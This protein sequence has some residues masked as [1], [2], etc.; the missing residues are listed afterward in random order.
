MQIVVVGN[1][2]LN[3]DFSAL[4]DGADEVIR[5]NRANNFGGHGGTRTTVLCIANWGEIGRKIA[6]RQLLVG[7]PCFPLVREF[8]FSRPSFRESAF[9]WRKSW[10]RDIDSLDYSR[11]IVRRNSLSAR[12]RIFF[13]ADIYQRGLELCRIECNSQIPTLQPTTGFLGLQYVLQR[14]GACDA[15]ISL[16]GFAFSGWERHPWQA[17]QAAVEA[18]EREGRIRWLR[19]IR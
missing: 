4:I 5:F 13:G 3:E 17:E 15:R 9:L 16:V 2:A 11:A 14:Y 10:R 6:K 7:L 19:Q 18:Y 12:T 1:A 8:W